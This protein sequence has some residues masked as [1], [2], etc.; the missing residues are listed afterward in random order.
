[1]TGTSR[2]PTGNRDSKGRFTGKGAFDSDFPAPKTC[3]MPLEQA[4]TALRQ[5]LEGAF[6][7][8]VDARG[9]KAGAERSVVVCRASPGAGKSWMTRL[10]LAERYRQK[11]E[12]RVAFHLPTLALSDE[13]ANEARGHGLPAQ[14]IRGR[15]A[16]LPDGNGTMCDKADLLERAARLGISLIRSFC[17]RRGEKGRNRLCPHFH[18]SAYLSQFRT[19]AKLHFMATNYLAFSETLKDSDFLVVDEAF[20]R[21]FVSIRD[22]PAVAFTTPRTHLASRRAKAHAD[23]LCAASDVVAAMVSGRSPLDLPYSAEDFRGFFR[24]E[25]MGKAPNPG[26]FPDQNVEEQCRRLKRAERNYRQVAAFAMIWRILADAKEAGLSA[27]ERLRIVRDGDRLLIRI[28]RKRPPKHEQPMLVLD[29]D[30][31]PL[32]LSALDCNVLET[33][34]IALRPNATVIQ[35]HDRRMTK[36]SLRSNPALR[37]DWR[38]IIAREVLIDRLGPRGGVLVGASK[39]VVRQFFEDAGHCFD[40]MKEDEVSAV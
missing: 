18:S 24:L 12:D 22:V 39:Q 9:D 21:Q 13:A 27:T 20:W 36:K 10:L 4:E 30:A 40:G 37:E 8:L 25:W 7:R 26:L 32:I 38:R 3:F 29:A 15:T 1:M 6:E 23:L 17:R 28:C 31:D 5:A 16:P 35:L 14:A 11:K 33:H 34:D 2:K 19:D